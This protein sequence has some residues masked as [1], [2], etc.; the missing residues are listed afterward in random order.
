MIDLA[1]VD[2]AWVVV[3]IVSLVLALQA[4]GSALFRL[5][6]APLLPVSA[7]AVGASTRRT[8]GAGL[9]AL[10]AQCLIEPAHLAGELSGVLDPALAR[11]ALS[12]S[13]AEFATRLGGLTCLVLGARSGRPPLRKVT[14]AGIAL[15]ALSYLLSGHTSVHPLR[16]LLAPLLFLHVLIVAWWFGALRPLHRATRLESQAQVAAVL[17]AFS[18]V[19]VWLVPA[20]ALAGI[21]MA[22]VLLPDLAALRRPYGLLLLTKAGLFAVLLGLAAVNRLSLVP[23]IASG[24]GAALATLRATLNCEYLLIAAVVAATAVM[25]GVYSPS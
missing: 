9:L 18:R 5:T 14:L 13:G 19:A 8:A 22:A 2:L 24:E 11:L 10:A 6:L 20:I 12:A 1:W 21:I 3:R 25:T 23:R 16:A 15:T 17:G 4:A 7:A